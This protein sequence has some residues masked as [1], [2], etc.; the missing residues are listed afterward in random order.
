MSTLGEFN[1]FC[2]LDSVMDHVLGNWRCQTGSHSIHIFLNIL[3]ILWFY[4]FDAKRARCTCTLEIKSELDLDL[5]MWGGM[6]NH[7]SYH[8]FGQL[9]GTCHDWA[10]SLTSGFSKC[11]K[12]SASL[13]R[14]QNATVVLDSIVFWYNHLPETINVWLLMRASWFQFFVCVAS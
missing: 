3:H 9:D 10:I 5:S 11:N 1:T 6:T 8:R 2:T 4:H 14:N 13:I 12:T 7:S